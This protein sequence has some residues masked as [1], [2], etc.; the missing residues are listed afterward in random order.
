MERACVLCDDGQIQVRDLPVHVRLASFSAVRSMAFEEGDGSVDFNS[1]SLPIGKTL[2][3]VISTI[4]R[5]F[6]EE[7]LLFNGGIRERAAQML[8]ISTATLYRKIE[9]ERRSQPKTVGSMP[10][11]GLF[12]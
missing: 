2:E 4:E 5:R 11:G 1:V 8:G 10:V 7:T 6:I 9:N 12:R 3:S